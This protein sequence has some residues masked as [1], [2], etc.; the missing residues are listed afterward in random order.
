MSGN[1]SDYLAKNYLQYTFDTIK[2][3]PLHRKVVPETPFRGC[4]SFPYIQHLYPPEPA[5]VTSGACTCYL[6]ES[7]NVLL[8]TY[9]LT[10]L[11]KK[12]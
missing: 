10:I 5:R 7:A 6:E 1:R 4:P 2:C 12:G 11:K 3:V 9:L 8:L